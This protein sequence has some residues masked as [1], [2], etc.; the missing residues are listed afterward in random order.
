[1]DDDSEGLNRLFARAL[2]PKKSTVPLVDRGLLL[3]LRKWKWK[4]TKLQPSFF[5][6]L[7][8]IRV[9]KFESRRGIESCM[10]A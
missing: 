7:L 2:R 10:R 9:W 4:Y 8:F 3:L 5:L 1:M 6:L